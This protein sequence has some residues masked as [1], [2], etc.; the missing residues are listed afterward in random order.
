MIDSV[1]ISSKEVKKLLDIEESH[2]CDLK[3]TEVSPAKLS[4]AIAAFSNAEGGELFIGIEDNPREW[5]GFTNIESANSHLQVFEQLFPLGTDY[6]YQF[7]E[8]D[9]EKGLVL[10]VQVAKTRDLKTATDGKVY[11]RRGA[12]S[13]PVTDEVRLTSL[14]RDKGL[15]SFESELVNCPEEFVTNSI[16]IIEFLIEVVPTAEPEPWLKKQMALQNGKVTVVAVLL[17]AEE[18]QAIVPKRSG[19]KIYRYKTSAEEGSRE[20]LDFDPVSIDGNVYSQI[21]NSV[22]QVAKIVES[23][24]LQTPDGLVT[25]NYPQEA[26]H[27]IITNA[28]I[29]RDYSITDDI[30]IRIFDNRVEVLSPGTL[31]GHVT[32]ENIL[33]E[34]FARNPTLVR[35]INK[36]PN[37]PNKDVGEGLNTAF[38]SMRNLKLKPP[39]ICQDGGYVKVVLR[40][41]PLASPEEAILL[42]LLKHDEIANRNAREVCFIKSENKMKRILQNLVSSGLLEPVPGRTRY[43]AAYQL[44]EEG[45][46]AASKYT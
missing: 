42:Y 44:T 27:E 7:L 9:G 37:P 40:H 41:E 22:S 5:K 20:T 29:H 21:Y 17:F 23:V 12:Q 10:K 25:V 18:P 33:S 19:L 45:R 36:F 14:R 3:A 2:F 13:I 35:L 38:E 24:R 31:P 15:V 16:H 34:R 30:H 46:N 11:V 4:K 39:E 6:Q 1:K 8:N 43:T 26:I 32:A 28:V